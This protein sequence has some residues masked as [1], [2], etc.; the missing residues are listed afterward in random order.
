MYTLLLQ[1]ISSLVLFTSTTTDL[2]MGIGTGYNPFKLRL[3]H[4]I[5]EMAVSDFYL[6]GALL[7]SAVSA[8]INVADLIIR[9]R[10]YDTVV[11]E[12]GVE[13]LR[14]MMK[15]HIN[16]YM[17]KEGREVIIHVVKDYINSTEFEKKMIEIMNK[18][19]VNQKLDK[20]IL[21]MCT[22]ISELKKTTICGSSQ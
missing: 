18:S 17:D 1:D 2:D 22:Q 3:S 21:I 11:Q 9:K 14:E 4:I 7:V 8:V 20:L 19:E 13:S 10:S 12:K 16:E 6:A 5:M 15:D